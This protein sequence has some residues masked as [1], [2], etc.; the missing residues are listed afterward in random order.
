MNPP[1]AD[2]KIKVVSANAE[3]ADQVARIVRAADPELDVA[4]ASTP[5]A[6]LSALINGTRPGLL[7]VD[8]VD[9][10]D[11][12]A[13]GQFT[14]AYPDVE[15]IV[16]SSEQSPAFLMKA[17]QAG[18]REVLPPPVNPPALQSAVQ[19]VTRKRKPAEPAQLGDVF[20]FMACKGGS[21]ASFLAANFAHVLSTR[22][23][24][25]VALLDLALVAAPHGR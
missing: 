3:R 15:M 2:M 5:A 21:G 24:R 1:K 22:D 12:D 8:G 11:L 23:G 6:G 20:V 7:I 19:R 13:I 18:V 10:P 17:M 9:A 25:T 14:H 4:A 16:I